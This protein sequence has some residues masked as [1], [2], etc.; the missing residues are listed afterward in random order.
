MQAM[1]ATDLKTGVIYK[2]GEAPFLVLKYSHIKVARGG[3]TV[4]VKVKDLRT[5]SVFEKSYKGSDKVEDADVMRK[6][7]Q[8]VYR[9]VNGFVFMDPDTYDQFVIAEDIIGDSAQFLVEGQTVQVQYFEG[10]PIVVDLPISMTFEVTYTEPGYRG[11]TVSNVYKDATLGN[12]A[13]VK[14]PSFVKIGDRVKIDTR[15]GEYVS[16]A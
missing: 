5:G 6:N 13:Q 1:I 12:G 16:K 15:T 14:V 2:E 9:E 7:A 3:A 10:N 11:N 4:K 8:Y